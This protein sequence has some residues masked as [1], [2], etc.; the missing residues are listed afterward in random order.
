MVE[1]D[2]SEVQSALAQ[3]NEEMYGDQVHA[4]RDSR[5]SIGPMDSVDLDKH[6]NGAPIQNRPDDPNKYLGT[7]VEK[8]LA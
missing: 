1:I 7:A 6:Y 3:V 2:P 4:K 8:R 5:D